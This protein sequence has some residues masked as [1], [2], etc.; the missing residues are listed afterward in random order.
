MI[1]RWLEQYPAAHL[2]TVD[3]EVVNEPAPL[4]FHP[5][6]IRAKALAC[7]QILSHASSHHAQI[8]RRFERSMHRHRQLFFI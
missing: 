1:P 6:Q 3:L 8:V 5:A 7:T 2:D 4:S